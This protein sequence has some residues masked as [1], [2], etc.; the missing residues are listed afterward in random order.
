[1]VSLVCWEHGCAS[2]LLD[3]PT[4]ECIRKALDDVQEV[5]LVNGK[6]NIMVDGF[7]NLCFETLVAFHGG[8][9]TTVSLLTK[10]RE[11]AVQ[12]TREL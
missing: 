11:I 6:I 5:N 7:Q 2:L 8:E 4:F 9:Q 1:M 3:I 10:E 12:V